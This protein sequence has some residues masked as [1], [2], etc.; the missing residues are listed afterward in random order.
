MLINANNSAV[1]VVDI[2]DKLVPAVFESDRLIKNAKWLME[3]ANILN[4]PVLISEQ[5]P[6][7]LGHTVA[8]LDNLV[9]AKQKMEKLS[10]SCAADDDCQSSIQSLG[11]EQVIIIGMEA[12]VC[13]MQTALDLKSMG[14]EVFVVADVV[15][16][17]NP[18]DIELALQ[19]MRQGGIHIVGRE[20]VAFEWMRKSG[21]EEFKQI[22]RDYLR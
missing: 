15:S 3:I 5:Y 19:R 20:M 4:V 1:L 11:R 7:G 2:Q 16:S 14:K 6:K 10:F 22:S 13:V 12:H 8:V 18:K 9:Q 17:R 21:T